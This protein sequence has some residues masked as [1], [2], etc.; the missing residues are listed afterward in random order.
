VS[1]LQEALAE[2]EQLKIRTKLTLDLIA[3]RDQEISELSAEV[4]RLTATE[5]DA[6]VPAAAGVDVEG[7]ISE[8]RAHRSHVDQGFQT[9]KH[10][11]MTLAAAI[12]ELLLMAQ[13]EPEFGP[14]V[15]PMLDSLKE[16][17]DSGTAILVGSRSH[18]EEQAKLLETIAGG[19]AEG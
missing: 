10:V 18:I 3:G 11:Q 9:W 8:L 1:A 15:Y 6:A 4:E 5:P 16:I 12:K 7:L 17:T 2:L 14:T 19:A 13:K